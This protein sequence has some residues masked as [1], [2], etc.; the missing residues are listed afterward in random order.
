MG[1]LLLAERSSAGTAG[2]GVSVETGWWV[3]VTESMADRAA[4]A[5]AQP[6]FVR[7]CSLVIVF[8]AFW[9]S[10]M[11]PNLVFRAPITAPRRLHMSMAVGIIKCSSKMLS[12][13][14]AKLHNC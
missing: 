11:L 5:V 8:H 10:A 4:P 7:L 13:P 14:K 12:S 9:A 1:G 3:K 6:R 2:A